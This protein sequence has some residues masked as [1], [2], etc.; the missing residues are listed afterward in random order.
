MYVCL[1][2]AV[3]ETD[4]RRAIDDGARSVSQI[5]M[6][7]GAGSGCGSCLSHAQALID[8]VHA[9]RRFPLPMLALAA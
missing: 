2:H 1:C 3:T 6:A 5:T 7:T 9:I 8:E 4:V